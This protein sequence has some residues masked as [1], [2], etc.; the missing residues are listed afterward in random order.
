MR[1]VSR[2]ARRVFAAAALLIFVNAG[3]ALAAP[4][5]D[6]SDGETFFAKLRRHIVHVLEDVRV[7]WPQG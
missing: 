4:S 2:Y 6:R 5:R 7:I 1:Q 3:A